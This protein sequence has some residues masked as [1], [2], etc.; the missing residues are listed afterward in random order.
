MLRALETAKGTVG[1]NEIARISN[2]PKTTLEREFLE[3]SRHETCQ[4][5]LRRII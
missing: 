3:I 4:L 5:A 1:V 2:T